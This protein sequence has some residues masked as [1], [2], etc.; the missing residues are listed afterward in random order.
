VKKICS[1]ILFLYLFFPPLSS[2]ASSFEGPIQVKNLYPLFLHADQ[3]YL[4]KAAIENSLS[5]SISH[6]ST[7]TVEESSDWVIH[8]D[9]EI[10]ELNFRYKRI[11]NDLFELELNIPV[12]IIGSGFMD[13]FLEDY[14]DTFGF[15]DYGR[16]DR[17]HNEFLY[18]V[19]KE[20]SQVIKGRTGTR[21]GDIR[22]AVK[23]PLISSEGYNLGIK[24]NIEIPV[25]SAERG[26]SNG[27]LDAGISL[28]FD[29]SISEKIMTYWNLGAVFPGDVRGFERVNL[30]N[31]LYGSGALEMIL[32]E[33]FS[34]LMQL[35]GQ[36]EIYPHTGVD[37]V[38]GWAYLIAF[39]GRY[40]RGAGSFELSLTEDLNT[41]GVPDFIINFTYKVS[42]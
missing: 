36:S 33:K 35:Q 9:M 4:E 30:K 2:A 42:L 38:D 23:K 3:P 12:I 31:F 6:S 5:F 34:A 20:G 41:T 29:K 24:A 18:D 39:G 14:H 26:Y 7:Y 25:S 32:G 19:R 21:L 27:S 37:A 22:L 17:P 40:R 10:T 28:L 1:S 13:G 8:L 11:I 16:S 15:S